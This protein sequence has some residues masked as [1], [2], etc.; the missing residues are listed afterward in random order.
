MSNILYKETQY[1][2][3]LILILLLVVVILAATNVYLSNAETA[4]SPA[5]YVT[6][7]LLFTGIIVL[8]YKLDII[9]TEDEAILSFGIGLVKRKIATNR[10]DLASTKILKTTLLWG[11][12]YRFTPHGT[13]FNTRL[14]KAIHIK[15]KNKNSEFFVVTDNMEAIKTAIKKAQSISNT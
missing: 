15:T 12:G 10:L 9:I 5:I 8:F 13:L 1:F 4:A 7:T 6:T 14:G 2:R 3:T 11:I